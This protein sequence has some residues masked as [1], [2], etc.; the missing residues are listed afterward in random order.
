M[1]SES[2]NKLGLDGKQSTVYL[3]LLEMGEVT[4]SSIVKKTGVKRTTVY[5]AIELL[6]QQKLIGSTKHNKR[7]LYFA[8]DPRIILEQLDEKKERVNSLLP[9][10]L[11]LSGRFT[12]KPKVRYYEGVEGIERAYQDTL[13]YPDQELVGWATSRALSAFSSEFLYNQYLP[14]RIEKKIWVRVIAPD[15]KEMQ[16][17]KNE[18]SVSLRQTM[19]VSSEEYPFDVEINLYGKR[20]VAIMSFEEQFGMV[21]ESEKIWRTLKSLF[22]MNWKYAKSLEN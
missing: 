13:T 7:T 6:Q 20:M 22:E 10:L 12:R 9:Q 2:L 18:D 17:Y 3:A 8:E 4:I 19:L 1:N 15:T 16:K 11:A 21:I 5:A 14:K